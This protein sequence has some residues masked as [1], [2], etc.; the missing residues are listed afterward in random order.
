MRRFAAELREAGFE[1]DYRF[2]DSM[3]QGV[4]QH[5]DEFT[6]TRVIATEP[7]SFAAR[8]LVSKLGIEILSLPT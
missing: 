2:A 4:Q 7:N 3:Q 5:I 8:T 1:V 6:P